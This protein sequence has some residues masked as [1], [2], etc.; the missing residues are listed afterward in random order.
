MQPYAKK[1]EVN[2]AFDGWDFILTEKGA[3]KQNSIVNA[4]IILEN[5]KNIQGKIAYNNF[6]FDMELIDD[7]HL[8]TTTIK[9]GIVKNDL[10]PALLA[11]IE[12][13]YSVLFT[14]QNISDAL[15]N[16]AHRYEFNPVFD[17]FE[18]VHEE[19]DEVE[20][21]HEFFPTYLGV[22]YSDITT[23]MTKIWLVGAVAKTYEEEC[24]FDFVLDLIGGQGTGKTTILQKLGMKWYT[25]SITDLKDK[26]NFSIMLRS[27]IVND[28][29]M[30]ATQ[31]SKFEE[32]KKFVTAI[33]LEFRKPFDRRPE[34]Y[35][36]NFVIA[37][38]TNEEEYLKDKTGERRFLPLFANPSNQLK[39]PAKDLKQEEIDLIWGE[40]VALYKNGYP[41]NLTKEQERQISQHREQFQFKDDIEQAI[42]T[43]LEIP[44][45]K[46]F[47]SYDDIDRRYYI[48]DMM[49]K[50][51]S[52][53]AVGEVVRDRIS[54]A[55]LSY[56]CFGK[57]ITSDR[58]LS[59]KIKYIMDNKKEWEKAS[60]RVNGVTKRGY[61]KRI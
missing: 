38:T 40:A 13:W 6:T 16:V 48:Q 43:Y 31:N 15:I 46:G 44:V 17:Y 39:Y 34:R 55:D 52:K 49:T 27:L 12:K 57:D 33:S 4:E 59:N 11:Y 23:L 1:K 20:R 37:R 26:D 10:E 58:R 54:S 5:D 53:K 8:G 3:I 32:I 50:G 25:D 41:I 36:K 35:P 9:K 45:P 47:E 42:D 2:A 60:F 51:R 18:R 14:K 29:E 28:D 61:R 19:W 7:I 22:E 21:L 56:E 24:K 30:V